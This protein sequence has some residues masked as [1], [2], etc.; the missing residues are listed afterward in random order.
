MGYHGINETQGRLLQLL[1]ALRGSAEF[2]RLSR[3]IENWAGAVT[4]WRVKNRRVSAVIAS[5][6][7]GVAALASVPAPAIADPGCG[8]V[9]IT[10]AIP[11]GVP[12]LSWSENLAYDDAG[13]LWV[14]RAT[15]QV[16][17]RYDSAGRKT[18]SVDVAS[19]GAVRLGPD[20]RMYATSGASPENLLLAGRGAIVSFD[21][22][23]PRKPRVVTRGLGMPNGL[24]VAGDGAMY[25]ADSA[26]GV[27]RIRPNGS[28]D[29]AW[30]ARAPKS[31]APT[32]V[33]NGLA[34]NGLAL[35]GDALYAG[36]TESLSGRIVRIPLERPVAVTVAVDATAPLPGFVDD[37]AWLNDRKLAATTTTGQV[38]VTDV[39]SG[40][41]CTVSANRPLTSIAIAP[42]RKSVVAGT[43]DGAVLRLRGGP[44]T[45]Q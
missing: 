11:A 15:G 16:I 25:V 37:L 42:D 24:V 45:Q 12:V 44:F 26:L 5:V 6:I 21:P 39:P 33:V 31:M 4:L 1:E 20:G 8:P 34:F 19:P 32:P 7:V 43:I 2:R 3:G 17:E 41:R 27:V 18:A 30:T 10:E 40:V 36:L 13:A 23:Q 35:R 38:V 28:I 9:R 22:A 29:R 14:S